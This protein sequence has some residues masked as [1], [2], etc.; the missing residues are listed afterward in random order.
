MKKVNWDISIKSL[1]SKLAFL[2]LV[3]L[4]FSQYAVAA[5]GTT[6]VTVEVD[7]TPACALSLSAGTVSMSLITGLSSSVSTN[8]NIACTTGSSVNIAVTSMNSWQLV[9][10][11]TNQKINY[12]LSYTGG[13]NIDGATV[14]PTWS[15]MSA[16]TVVM[17]GTATATAWQ[18]P[19]TVLTPVITHTNAVDVYSDTVTIEALY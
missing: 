19:L 1:F 14:N 8:L 10:A 9:G 11:S 5:T 15:G 16:G 4:S 12:T 17:S 2:A 6:Q 18:V 3:T 7:V 13:G